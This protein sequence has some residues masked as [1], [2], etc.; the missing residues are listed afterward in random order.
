MLTSSEPAVATSPS[1]RAPLRR[2]RAPGASGDRRRPRSTTRAAPTAARTAEATPRATTPKRAPTRPVTT[3]VTEATATEHGAAREA[4]QTGRRTPSATRAHP[5]GTRA[6][7]S[8]TTTATAPRTTT[9][10]PPRGHEASDGPRHRC[11]GHR[12]GR[13]HARDGGPSRGAMVASPGVTARAPAG[14][15]GG[16]D[17]TV[18][19]RHRALGAQLAVPVSLVLVAG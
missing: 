19:L 16:R 4:T 8:A 10:S 6:T 7:S 18:P 3:P 2:T 12:V 1:T 14:R 15:G 9:P 5:P 13:A 11:G 17:V